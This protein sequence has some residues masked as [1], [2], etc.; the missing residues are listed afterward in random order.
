MVGGIQF[1]RYPR[2]LLSRFFSPPD[3]T[4]ARTFAEIAPAAAPTV[5]ATPQMSTHATVLT[6]TSALAKMPKSAPVTVRTLPVVIPPVTSVADSISAKAV[7]MIAAEAGLGP[8]DLSDE[9]GFA[10]IGVDS[11]MSLVISEKFR[12]DL[13]IT[14][15]GSL[16]LEYPTV[17]ALRGWLEEY[18]N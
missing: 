9:V 1:R 8:D 5:V 12:Q 2:I 6:T 17:G 14:V 15:G 13:S 16:F 7:A 4:V 18:Y 10:D 11:L 3:S